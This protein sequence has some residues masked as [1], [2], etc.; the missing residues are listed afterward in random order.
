MTCA[1]DAKRKEVYDT[2][3]QEGTVSTAQIAERCHIS[4]RSA[5]MI[6]SHLQQDGLIEMGKPS[7]LWTVKGDC[8]DT[9]RVG[10]K[11]SGRMP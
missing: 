11:S 7:T 3:V 8:H 10:R 9:D 4:V 2:V 6:L 1:D 5:G